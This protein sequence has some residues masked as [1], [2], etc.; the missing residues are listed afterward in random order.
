[1]VDSLQRAVSRLVVFAVGLTPMLVYWVAGLIGQA[2]RRKRGDARAG[3]RPLET[4]GEE[5]RHDRRE[6]APTG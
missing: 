6:A 2:F 3:S 4:V 1:V 5:E